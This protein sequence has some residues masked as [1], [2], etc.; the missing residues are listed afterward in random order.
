[1]MEKHYT[2]RPASPGIAMGP[3]VAF[4]PCAGMRVASGNVEI[5]TRALRTALA[6]ALR[7]LRQLIDQ[8]PKETAEIL[9]FQV[10][11]LEDSALAEPAL[12]TIAA[13]R[14]AHDAWHDAMEAEAAGY[15][16][17]ADEYF[18]ARAA[19]LRDIR[20]RVL[21]S[22]AGSDPVADVPPGA[23]VVAVDLAPSRFLGIDWSR[24]GALVLTAGSATSHI[25][26]LAR[27][28][29]IPAVVGLGIELTELSGDALVDAHRGVLTV[30][31][32]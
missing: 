13:G 19:D 2:G 32:G 10:A 31:P 25:A 14:A 29:G 26:M 9:G 4:V 3:L 1:M 12:A 17:S 6:S 5:E 30:N 28:R 8:S 20:D 21:T 16:S 27:S 15:E 11:L 24:G 22:L 18:R 23:V 7:E